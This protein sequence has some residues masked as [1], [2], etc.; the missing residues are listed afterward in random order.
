LRRFWDHP[1]VIIRLTDYPWW[2]SAI[3]ANLSLSP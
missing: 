1:E 3:D 2:Q